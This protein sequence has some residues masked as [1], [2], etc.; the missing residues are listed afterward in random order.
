[1]SSKETTSSS[2]TKPAP[3]TNTKSNRLPA[4][5]LFV[6]PPSHNASQLSV[7]RTGGG[8]GKTAR[9]PLMRT[10]SKLG[11]ST[12]HD[13]S[14]DANTTGTTA[15]ATLRRASEKSVDGKW[16][17]MQN[18]L[19]EVELTAQSS[20]HVFGTSHA[21]A[22][23]DLRKAQ[24]ELAKAW[25][26]GN[27]DKATQ[28]A[29]KSVQAG[30]DHLNRFEG[31]QPIASDRVSRARARG[32][33]DASASTTLSDESSATAG[34][35]K[36]GISQMEEETAQD[37]RLAS[38]RRAANEAYFKKV[39]ESVKD[40]VSRLEVVAEA[41]RGVEGESRSLW[42]GSSRTSDTTETDGDT[43]NRA[44]TAVEG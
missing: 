40:V 39:D 5:S 15:F 25:G 23:E 32:G 20:T 9:D 24:V 8:E 29:E 6:G 22:L 11:E 28:A 19:N 7:S 44:Q 17:E 1:M 36:S 10:K 16:R 18:T 30:G 21:A 33:T 26:R 4:P 41:M 13:H 42:S 31:S 14:K 38:E 12:N 34:T 43:R 27:E 2:P 3:S 35:A 37:I